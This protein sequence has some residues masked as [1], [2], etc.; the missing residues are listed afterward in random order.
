MESIFF[1]LFL[2]ALF[3]TVFLLMVLYNVN[4]KLKCL[5]DLKEYYEQEVV[6]LRKQRKVNDRVHVWPDDYRDSPVEKSI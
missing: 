2:V 3:M 4:Q 1:I 6:R 5:A